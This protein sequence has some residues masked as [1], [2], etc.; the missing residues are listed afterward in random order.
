MRN[1]VFQGIVASAILTVVGGAAAVLGFGKVDA[2]S[3][4]SLTIN[5]QQ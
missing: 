4:F 2:A 1:P 3:D 5:V